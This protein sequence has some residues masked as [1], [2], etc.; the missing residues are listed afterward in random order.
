MTAPSIAAIQAAVCAFYRIPLREMTS[1]R[2]ERAA[3][4]ARQVGMYI[5]RELTPC[6]Y[7]RIGRAFGKRDHTTIMYA[8]K[9]VEERMADDGAMR[10]AIRGLIDALT[11]S[12]DAPEADSYPHNSRYPTYPQVTHLVARPTGGA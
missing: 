3:A 1:H 7:P 4:H 12:E 8:V 9:V 2:R 6:S 5:A 10:I 11:P